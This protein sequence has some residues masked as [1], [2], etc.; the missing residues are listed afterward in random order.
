MFVQ[1]ISRQASLEELH[2][3]K[4]NLTGT[5]LYQVLQALRASECINSIKTLKLDECNWESDDACQ[6]LAT[7]ISEAPKLELVRLFN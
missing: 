7:I 5:M 4:N 3:H 6:E 1:F 2:L